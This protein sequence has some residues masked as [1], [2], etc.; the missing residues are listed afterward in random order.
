MLFLTNQNP[1]QLITR[2]LTPYRKVTKGMDEGCGIK[3]FIPTSVTQDD[4]RESPAF[5]S[6]WEAPFCC[7]TEMGF[8]P[9]AL[10]RPHMAMGQNRV[11]PDPNPHEE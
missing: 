8:I 2:G 4:A 11:P 6:L 1:K 5:M 9:T 3:G 7:I 10:A